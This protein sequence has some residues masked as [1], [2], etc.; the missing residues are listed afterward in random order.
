M[1]KIKCE[2]GTIE[3]DGYQGPVDGVTATCSK[4]GHETQ[5]FGT[6]QRSVNRCLVALNE[7][8]PDEESNLYVVE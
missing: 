1:A 7:E 4:C 8:C 5:S 3:L 6:S 2:I